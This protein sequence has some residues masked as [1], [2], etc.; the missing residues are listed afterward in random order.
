MKI[1]TS[2]SPE[3]NEA[4]T[5][6]LSKFANAGEASSHAAIEGAKATKP[7]LHT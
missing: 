4:F 5:Q 2:G 3:Q 1:E 7:S 6:A